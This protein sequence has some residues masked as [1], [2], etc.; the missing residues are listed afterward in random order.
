M[1][2]EIQ[3]RLLRAESEEQD[4]CHEKAMLRIKDT[5]RREKQ[6]QVSCMMAV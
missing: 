4:I 1:I 6:S 2:V 5:Y 3:K